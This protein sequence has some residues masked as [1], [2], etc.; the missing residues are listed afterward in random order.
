MFLL[1]IEVSLFYKELGESLT[2]ILLESP[3]NDSVCV[4][5][6]DWLVQ[7]TIMSLT[8]WSL[9][10][11]LWF[12]PWALSLVNLSK[13]GEDT[14]MQEFRRSEPKKKKRIIFSG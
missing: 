4:C 11:G 10:S 6:V 13:T 3:V 12:Q 7:L 5:T 2:S 14:R 1:I 8:A 9:H